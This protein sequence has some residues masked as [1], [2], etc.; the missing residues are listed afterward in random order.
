[1]VVIVPGKSMIN[2]LSEDLGKGGDK[3]FEIL[4]SFLA[5]KGEK[6]KRCRHHSRV[7]VAESSF[8]LGLDIVDQLRALVV[9]LYEDQHCLFPYHLVLVRQKLGHYLLHR[10]HH[11]LVGQLGQDSEGR[12]HLPVALRLQVSLDGPNEQD[13]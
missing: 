7:R 13:E 11:V 4:G 8:H 10:Q 9:E 1:M 5:L 12:Q 6:G 2:N 3:V